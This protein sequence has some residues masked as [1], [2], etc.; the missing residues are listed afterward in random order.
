MKLHLKNI[1]SYSIEIKHVLSQNSENFSNISTTHVVIKSH[2]LA[3]SI[4]TNYQ[5][6]FPLILLVYEN[7]KLHEAKL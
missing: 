6:K 4:I 5:M 7:N 1:L 3:V 2:I